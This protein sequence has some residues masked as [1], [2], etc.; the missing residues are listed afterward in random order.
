LAGPFRLDLPVLQGVVDHA[1]PATKRR[2]GTQ[3]HRRAGV[4]GEQQGVHQLEQRVGA[5]VE[6]AQ[7]ALTKLV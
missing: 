1:K 7:H 2:A 6:D 4:E 5:A 3:L